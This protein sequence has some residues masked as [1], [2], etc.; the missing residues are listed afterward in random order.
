MSELVVG[1]V[2]KLSD[3]RREEIIA[4]IQGDFKKQNRLQNV[5]QPTVIDGHRFPSKKEAQEYTDLKLRESAGDISHLQIQVT[6]PLVIDDIAIFPRGYVA[7][8]TF[9][10]RQKDRETWKLVVADAKGVKTDVYQIKKRLMLAI[11]GITIR[12]S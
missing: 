3:P 1:S 4:E 5:A 6:F 9:L 7:D 10:E 11:W 8:F 12:E 2:V